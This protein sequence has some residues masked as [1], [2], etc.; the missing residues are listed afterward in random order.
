MGFGQGKSPS[1]FI[2]PALYFIIGAGLIMV[3]TLAGWCYTIL[4]TVMAVSTQPFLEIKP[5]T[6][7]TSLVTLLHAEHLI[8]APRT[9]LTLI[10]L[11]GLSSILKAGIYP[12]VP[13]ETVNQFLNKVVQGQVL[14]ETF[15]IIEGTTVNQISKNLLQAPFL[16]YQPDNWQAISSGYPSAEG[17]LLADTYHY[18]A[19]SNGRNLLSNAHKNLSVLLEDIWSSRDKDL[20][21]KS[22]YELLIA[23]SILEKET[24]LPEERS[25]IS[26][27]IVNRLKK[28]MPLQMDP[29][30]IYA[31]GNQ[32]PSRLTHADLTINSP[33]NTYR[34]RGLPPTP[35]AMVGKNSLLAAAHPQRSSY[36]YFVAKGDGSHYFSVNYAEQKK[37][38]SRYLL[39]KK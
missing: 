19:G 8:N 34:F 38:I 16:H 7:A 9:L 10:R 27:V 32:Y 5:N 22:S 35:I 28:N 39:N 23:A 20:P 17:M 24:S 21:Y 37:A 29:T 13:G 26:G 6:T 2:K 12:L 11:K 25:I 30:V 36:L 15:L 31:L 14:T 1:C 33:Y 4:N 18:D 3:L